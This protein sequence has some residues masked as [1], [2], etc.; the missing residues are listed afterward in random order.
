MNV[1]LHDGLSGIR[2]TQTTPGVRI[3]GMPRGERD[4]MNQTSVFVI[5]IVI[6]PVFVSVGRGMRGRALD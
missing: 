3:S 5:M 4:W 2:Y 1:A 6:D